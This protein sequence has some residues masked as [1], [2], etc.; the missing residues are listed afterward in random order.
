M[1]A[2][3]CHAPRRRLLA[4]AC[5]IPLLA[6]AATAQEQARN[7]SDNPLRGDDPAAGVLNQLVAAGYTPRRHAWRGGLEP[8]VENEIRTTLCAGNHYAVLLEI[9]GNAELDGLKVLDEV[10]GDLEVEFERPGDTLRL[11]KF[12]AAYNGVY[13]LVIP[14]FDAAAGEAARLLVLYK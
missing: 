6:A 4:A 1:S 10:G 2:A 11:A 7:A 5:A 9:A 8:G 12:T 3:G 14:A 13:R